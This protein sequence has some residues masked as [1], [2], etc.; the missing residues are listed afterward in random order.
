MD[1]AYWDKQ[2]ETA[3][4]KY[5]FDLM[6]EAV[7]NGAEPDNIILHRVINH[8]RVDLVEYFC[9]STELKKHCDIN[10]E[11]SYFGDDAP[12]MYACSCGSVETFKFML[13]DERVS[14]KFNI[15][16]NAYKGF[17]IAC[18]SYRLEMVKFL[19]EAPETKD[20]CNI[21]NNDFEI[22]KVLD[23]EDRWY[24][25]DPL[26]EI[27][28]YL[29]MNLDLNIVQEMKKHI[30]K[31][32]DMLKPIFDARELHEELNQNIRQANKIKKI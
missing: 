2:L 10:Y 11:Y 8:D 26:K 27:I 30:V 23:K 19:L 21:Q 22:I 16:E 25:I 5:N 24:K 31:H 29:I 12:M 9:F 28:E 18:T 32:K 1:K 3:C 4:S 15:S 7:K 6:K 13:R 17:R 14:H 20:F